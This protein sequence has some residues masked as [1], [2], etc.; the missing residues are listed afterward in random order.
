MAALNQAYSPAGIVFHHNTSGS[1]YT[2]RDDWATDANGT[3]MKESLR[4]GTY[5]S[6]NIYFQSNLSSGGSGQV[7][8]LLGYCSLPT[9]ITY[10]S[11]PVEYPTVDYATDGCN[12]LTGSMPGVPNAVYGYNEGKTAVHEVGHWFGLLHT[13]QVTALPTQNMRRIQ[14]R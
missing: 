1:S 4:R 11:P 2:I 14:Y 12:I 3:I 8:T 5:A 9:V 6:L 7:S 13:F 10:G